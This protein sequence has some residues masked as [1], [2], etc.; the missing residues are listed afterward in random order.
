MLIIALVTPYSITY[1]FVGKYYDEQLIII[2]AMLWS[3]FFYPPDRLEFEFVFDP[4]YFIGLLII[5]CF[6]RI[7]FVHQIFRYY[8]GDIKRRQV[9]CV[10]LLGEAQIAVV[11][12]PV[13]MGL[14]PFQILVPIPI[15]LLAG[16]ILLGFVPPLSRTSEWIDRP[17]SEN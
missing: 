16:L 17:A 10:G 7:A 1:A 5:R 15:L 13:L 3:I 9:V 11:W 8:Q 12:I 14:I 6:F 4:T 2:L